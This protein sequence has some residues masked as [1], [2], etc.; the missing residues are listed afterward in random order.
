MTRVIVPMPITFDNP[1]DSIQD[2]PIIAVTIW[3]NDWRKHDGRR[4][5][6]DW[7]MKEFLSRLP[8]N[9]K[10]NFQRFGMHWSPYYVSYS[11]TGS[12]SKIKLKVCRPA[13][14]SMNGEKMEAAG[15]RPIRRLRGI[16]RGKGRKAPGWALD[17][18]PDYVENA[19]NVQQYQ[20]WDQ[21]YYLHRF[22][23][24][25]ASEKSLI[26]ILKTLLNKVALY[27]SSQINTKTLNCVIHLNPKLKAKT[28]L[29]MGLQSEEFLGN[30]DQYFIA[31]PALTTASV[32]GAE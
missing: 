14:E 1:F 32:E 8:A 17:A 26:R 22:C 12:E 5:F 25:D 21:Q 4:V 23:V 28:D 20:G 24:P 13:P 18:V 2:D 16:Y 6:I 30:V 10:E 19:F 7:S 11:V 27:A 31:K 9:Q 29:I 15:I 3:L